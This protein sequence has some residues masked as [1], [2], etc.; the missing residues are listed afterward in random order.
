MTQNNLLV[1]IAILATLTG[2]AA[3]IQAQRTP[4]IEAIDTDGPVTYFIAEGSKKSHYKQTDYEL[5]IWALRAW[6]KSV[7]GALQFIPGSETTALLRVYWVPAT[8]GQ[9]GE[10]WPLSVDGKRGAGVFIRPNIDA[11]GYEL[12]QQAKVDPLFRDTIVYLTCLHELGHALGLSHTT[13]Y[14]DIMYS[15]G[16]G[17]DIPAFFTRY[18][19]QLKSR[20]DIKRITGLSKSDISRLRSLYSNS[21]ESKIDKN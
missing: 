10:M 17:G 13:D 11:L 12:A 3:A 1:F 5:A 19:D 8:S 18:R 16:F 9:Y 14:A 20:Q 21:T 4:E 7:D 2:Y 15:F 6:E